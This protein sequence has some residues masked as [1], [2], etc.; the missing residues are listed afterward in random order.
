MIQSPGSVDVGQ[1]VVVGRKAAD[2]DGD[3]LP[4]T[5]PEEPTIRRDYKGLALSPDEEIGTVCPHASDRSPAWVVGM[6]LGGQ[7]LEHVSPQQ[8]HLWKRPRVLDRR[9]EHLR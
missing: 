3:S 5:P 7:C 6:D 4:N 9:R 8:R 1:R 2:D